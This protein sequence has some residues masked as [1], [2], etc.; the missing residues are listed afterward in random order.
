[1]TFN[2]FLAALPI[3]IILILML[4]FRWSAARAGLA[5]WLVAIFISTISF[6]AGL[7]LLGY[8]QLKALLLTLD[9]LLIVWNAFL[10][11][12]VTDE[13][14]AIK[15]FSTAL[16]A[17]T[18]DRAMQALLSVLAIMFVL[19]LGAGPEARTAEPTREI[20]DEEYDALV[21]FYEATNGDEWFDHTDW[22]SSTYS[23]CIWSGVVCGEGKP[24][25]VV[26]ISLPR[27]NVTGQLPTALQD[28]TYLQRLDLEGNVLTGTIPM[29]LGSLSR[30]RVVSAGI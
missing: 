26:S 8:A 24:R 22:L 23:P 10:L 27:N 12:R 21:A 9:V 19:L 3:I 25:H 20:P 4:G 5:G 11:F 30:V 6:G 13:A 2:L 18:P 29:G 14:G 15:I 28:L 7:R 16:P 1:M 17:L